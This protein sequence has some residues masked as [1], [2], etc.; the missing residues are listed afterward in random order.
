MYVTCGII[1]QI[2][3]V[4]D[5]QVCWMCYVAEFCILNCKV[6]VDCEQ[7]MLGLKVIQFGVS[8][9]GFISSSVLWDIYLQF[10]L[11][12]MTNAEMDLKLI[13]I[14]NN[15]ILNISCRHKLKHV[16]PGKHTICTF[17]IQILHQFWWHSSTEHIWIWC[18]CCFLKKLSGFI[19]LSSYCYF[20]LKVKEM[21]HFIIDTVFCGCPFLLFLLKYTF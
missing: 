1:G 20:S 18:F 6:L 8:L 5:T 16:V 15:L 4:F 9:V 12:I 17:I 21:F 11:M 13:W 2:K 14:N 7:N 3:L 19:L 10:A